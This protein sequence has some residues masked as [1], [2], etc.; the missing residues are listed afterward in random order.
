MAITL[1]SS[2]N[3]GNI[4]TN[5]NSIGVSKPSSTASGD[6]LVAIY[7]VSNTFGGG[8]LDTASITGSGW[9]QLEH[10][11]AQGFSNPFN[12][13]IDAVVWYKFA[14]SSEPT[15]YTMA[16]TGVVWSGRDNY[17]AGTVLRL[18]NGVNTN[19]LVIRA[20][21]SM[22][23][24]YGPTANSISG[25]IAADYAISYAVSTNFDSNP[26][27]SQG[28][29]FSGTGW[30]SLFSNSEAQ[31]GTYVG[32]RV[33][34][35]SGNPASQP[36]FHFTEAGGDNFTL[37]ATFAIASAYAQ[38]NT[39]NVSFGAQNAGRAFLVGQK[40]RASYMASVAGDKL[41]AVDNPAG[42]LVPGTNLKASQA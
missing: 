27:E 28:N 40:M 5:L 20:T 4:G 2:A 29:S 10:S 3:N 26:G 34:G 22:V 35:A 32:C 9:T 36:T 33:L 24:G 23:T 1:G 19:G 11:S 13:Y 12:I 14:G 25:V 15:T 37:A 41:R 31:N 38:P 39:A 8:N 21:N 17:R 7:F 42:P 16:D 6:F 18:T 30:T